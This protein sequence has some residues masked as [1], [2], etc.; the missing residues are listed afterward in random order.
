MKKWLFAFLLVLIAFL[1]WLKL[2][3]QSASAQNLAVNPGNINPLTATKIEQW[4]A[5]IPGLRKQSGFKIYEFWDMDQTNQLIGVPVAMRENGQT[6]IYNANF[7][8]LR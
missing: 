6:I 4:K 3:N 1:V 5:L 8:D 2:P 7:V